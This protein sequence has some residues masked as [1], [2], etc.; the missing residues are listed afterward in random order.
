[1]DKVRIQQLI[2]VAIAAA[3]FAGGA[4]VWSK[5]A[6]A[7]AGLIGLATFLLGVLKS[8]PGHTA[9][10]LPPPAIVPLLALL[11]LPPVL[12]GCAKYAKPSCEII[13]IADLACATLVLAD[14]SQVALSKADVANPER[15]GAALKNRGAVVGCK[16]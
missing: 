16:P 7:G 13:H 14:G 11:F 3:C 6:E 8:G 9:G 1:M 2:I 15:L 4:L 12:G 10:D 5:S